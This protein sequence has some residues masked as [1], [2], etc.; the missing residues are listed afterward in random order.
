MRQQVLAGQEHA[1][2]I[3]GEHLVPVLFAQLDRSATYA[4]PHI[5]DKHIDFSVGID[6]RARSLSRW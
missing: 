4:D 1:G 6:A 2:K 3:G 5:V